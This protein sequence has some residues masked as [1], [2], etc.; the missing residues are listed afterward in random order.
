MSILEIIGAGV[1]AVVIIVAIGH[2]TGFWTCSF[3]I[4]KRN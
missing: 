4:T 3:S 1:V 2:A